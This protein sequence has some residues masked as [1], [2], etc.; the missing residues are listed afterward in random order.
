MSVDVAISISRNVTD[1]VADWYQMGTDYPGQTPQV[2][3]LAPT[4]SSA[5]VPATF[6]QQQKCELCCGNNVHDVLIGSRDVYT[7]SRD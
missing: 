1:S 7:G 2:I 4:C 6:F 5:K 3:D